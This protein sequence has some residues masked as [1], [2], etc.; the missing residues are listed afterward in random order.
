MDRQ[1]HCAQ[2]ADLAVPVDDRELGKQDHHGAEERIAEADQKRDDYLRWLLRFDDE[3][4]GPW[5][6]DPVLWALDRTAAQIQD[7]QELI[8]E[9]VAYARELPPP[10][11]KYTFEQLATAARMSVSGVR[12]SYTVGDISSTAAKLVI[13]A[14]KRGAPADRRWDRAR[15]RRWQCPSKTMEDALDKLVAEGSAVAGPPEELHAGEPDSSHAVVEAFST[16]DRAY[17]LPNNTLTQL[18][19]E[20]LSRRPG[21]GG[22]PLRRPRGK[23]CSP[24]HPAVIPPITATQ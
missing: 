7:L 6:G 24:H 16:T 14:G 17:L 3:S 10:G 11:S 4:D 15:I 12:S 1:E 22:T 23:P 21:L 20:E 9:L 2:V 19:E 8:Y 18:L 5:G 13:G